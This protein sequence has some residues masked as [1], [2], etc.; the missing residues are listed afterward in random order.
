M[1]ENKNFLFWFDLS[2]FRKLLQHCFYNG[3]VVKSSASL[4]LWRSEFESRWAY[5][6]SVKF[7]FEKNQNE[8]QVVGVGLFV[9]KQ[10]SLVLL[11]VCPWPNR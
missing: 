2:W 1:C 7:V 3:A 11:W 5:T 4:Q 10:Y 6:V 8:Q 9:Q